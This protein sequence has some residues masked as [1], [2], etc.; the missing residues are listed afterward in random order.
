[1]DKY[2]ALDAGMYGHAETM[3]TRSEYVPPGLRV[4]YD[5]P[6]QIKRTVCE[7]AHYCTQCGVTF[8]GGT[9]AQD[10]PCCFSKGTARRWRK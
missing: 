1:M 8:H 4:Q 7:V 5:G 6:P 3:F 9:D 10:C 2:E